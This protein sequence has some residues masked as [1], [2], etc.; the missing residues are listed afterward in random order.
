MGCRAARRDKH[1]DTCKPG[2]DVVLSLSA[3]SRAVMGPHFDAAHPHQLYPDYV[4]HSHPIHDFV[5]ILAC[6][7]ICSPKDGHYVKTLKDSGKS[8]CLRGEAVRLRLFLSPAVLNRPTCAI[9]P[10]N[11]YQS[12]VPL[13]RIPRGGHRAATN[14]WPRREKRTCRL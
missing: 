2:A 3:M 8:G 13:Q 5:Q 7:H 10:V 9:A 1:S 11:A 14:C 4:C 12:L 6:S